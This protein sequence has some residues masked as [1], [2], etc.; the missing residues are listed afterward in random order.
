MAQVQEDYTNDSNRKTEK[1]WS[2]RAQKYYYK[3]KDPSYYRD[4]FH[5]HKQ[6]LTCQF[7]GKVVKCQ[8]YSHV[9]SLKCQLKQKELEMGKLKLS[10]EEANQAKQEALEGKGEGTIRIQSQIYCIV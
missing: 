7:C 3:V 2:E 10:L 5:N 4:Y 9:K 1:V 6:D 8:M